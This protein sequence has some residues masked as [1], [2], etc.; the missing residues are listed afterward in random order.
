MNDHYMRSQSILSRILPFCWVQIEALG[1]TT[2]KIALPSDAS[3]EAGVVAGANP[4]Q[5]AR[6]GFRERDIIRQI[7]GERVASVAQLRR[8]LSASDEWA[9]S[10]Q[11]GDQTMQL[12]VQ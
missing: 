4:M 7:N 9:I 3:R 10:I 11:R 2:T 5:G 1:R 6:F 8:A 12:S